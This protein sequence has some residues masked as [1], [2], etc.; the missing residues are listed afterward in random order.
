MSLIIFQRRN[1]EFQGASER[2]LAT[3]VLKNVLHKEEQ[4]VL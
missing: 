4:E 1:D 2:L 3:F